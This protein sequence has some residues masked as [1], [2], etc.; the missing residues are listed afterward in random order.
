MVLVD[1]IMTPARDPKRHRMRSAGQVNVIEHEYPQSRILHEISMMALVYACEAY[2]LRGSTYVYIIRLN[3]AVATIY[4]CFLIV[5]W[6]PLVATWLPRDY[7]QVIA[8]LT[9][10]SGELLR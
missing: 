3:H 8:Y 10:L 5:I 1:H 7:W 9:N 4:V 6:F 2:C